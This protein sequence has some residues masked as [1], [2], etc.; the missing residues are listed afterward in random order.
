MSGIQLK[1]SFKDIMTMELCPLNTIQC[2]SGIS[3][4]LDKKLKYRRLKTMHGDIR[5]L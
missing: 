1:K 3:K 5:G 2:L 4:V